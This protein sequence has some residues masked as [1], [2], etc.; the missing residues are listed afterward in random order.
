MC[1]HFRLFVSSCAVCYCVLHELDDGEAVRRRPPVRLESLKAT[2][3][4]RLPSRE[5]CEG[6]MRLVEERRKVFHLH[7]C[8][9][10]TCTQLVSICP[11][12]SPS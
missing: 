2:K 10:L 4:Q 7:I 1:K 5:E 3:E 8:V 6:K 12:V 11:V 9:H